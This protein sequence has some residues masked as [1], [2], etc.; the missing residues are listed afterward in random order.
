MVSESLISN[1]L[2][3]R[4]IKH[5]QTKGTNY[6][7]EEQF[8]GSVLVADISNFKKFTKVSEIQIVVDVMNQLCKLYR[9][10]VG[11]CTSVANSKIYQSSLVCF[12]YSKSSAYEVCKS[13]T[14][15]SKP[16]YNHISI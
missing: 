10:A 2:P 12:S 7:I 11:S 14:Q 3:K 13:I 16:K 5:I 8:E 4:I 6:L 9:S 15:F 1:I